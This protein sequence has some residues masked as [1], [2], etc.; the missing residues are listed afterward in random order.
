MTTLQKI[1]SEAAKEYIYIVDYPPE[2]MRILSEDENRI[3]EE[4]NR[5]M[6]M[7]NDDIKRRHNVKS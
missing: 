5:I 6:K 3:C 1:F 2:R 4:T 7:I